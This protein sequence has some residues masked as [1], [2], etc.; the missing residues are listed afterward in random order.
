[1]GTHE[2]QEKPKKMISAFTQ[3]LNAKKKEMVEEN[4]LALVVPNQVVKPMKQRIEDE[5]V[6]K[7][8]QSGLVNTEKLIK[9]RE[10]R[11]GEVWDKYEHVCKY[12]LPPGTETSKIEVDLPYEKVINHRTRNIKK[13]SGL[14]FCYNELPKEPHAYYFKYDAKIPK[15][16]AQQRKER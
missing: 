9:Q 2:L 7:K 15:M 14:V 4:P 12:V 8:K 3:E 5:S 6:N 13:D 10:E 16:Y 11:W 1:M